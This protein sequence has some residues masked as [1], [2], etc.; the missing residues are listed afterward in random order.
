MGELLQVVSH[1]EPSYRCSYEVAHCQRAQVV[2]QTLGS[3][4]VH[5]CAKDPLDGNLHPL[6]LHIHQ[7]LSPDAHQGEQHGQQGE[8]PHRET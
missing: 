4:L 5:L 8:E 3:D 7:H 1:D 6:V 2:Q